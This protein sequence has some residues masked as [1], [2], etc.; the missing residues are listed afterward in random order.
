MS[1]VFNR[2]RNEAAS[3]DTSQ[4]AQLA[5]DLLESLDTSA[6]RD[7]VEPEWNE[8]AAR[9]LA[10]FD[11]GDAITIAAADLHAGTALPQAR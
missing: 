3:L 9:R 1:S 5:L 8:E 6:R 4:R 7:F 11:R 10:R 2:L